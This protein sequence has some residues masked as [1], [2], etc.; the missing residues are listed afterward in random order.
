MLNLTYTYYGFKFTPAV[1]Q[2]MDFGLYGSTNSIAGMLYLAECVVTVTLW[3]TYSLLLRKG[4]IYVLLQ[5]FS[6][7]VFIV[8]ECYTASSVYL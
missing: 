2:R 8:S 1:S 5:V 6:T 4:A 7:S 3:G